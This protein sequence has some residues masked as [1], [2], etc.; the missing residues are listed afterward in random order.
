MRRIHARQVAART[1][2]AVFS[3]P[4]AAAGLLTMMICRLPAPPMQ[5]AGWLAAGLLFATCLPTLYVGLLVARRE[6]DG[7]YIAVRS[8][9]QKPLL[10]SSASCLAGFVV[11]WATG[12]P[13][14]IP[15]FLLGCFFL[16]LIA[17]WTNVRWKIS[18]HAA[19]VCGTMAML[20]LLL[21][22][23]SVYW[24]PLPLAVCWARV[25]IGAHSMRQVAAGCGV[26][27]VVV[28][29]VAFMYMYMNA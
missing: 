24:L 20:H 3:P 2:S 10:V 22:P 11:L 4:L 19:G 16:G 29:V 1:L 15:G 25:V 8:H 18:L 13:P 5:R 28:W 23:S 26:G 9:R 14:P 12:A 27:F 17:A 7:F 21:G 6:V